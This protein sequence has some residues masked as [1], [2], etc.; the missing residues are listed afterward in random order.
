M[1]R[2]SSISDDGEVAEFDS[3]V[4][5]G[6]EIKRLRPG[7]R[8]Q[9][10]LRLLFVTWFNSGQ[11]LCDGSIN[12]WFELLISQYEPLSFSFSKIVQLIC[13]LKIWPRRAPRSQG[14]TADGHGELRDAF[15]C[16]VC[17][18]HNTNSEQGSLLMPA[19]LV[20]GAMRSPEQHVAAV[21]K[22]LSEWGVDWPNVK[23]IVAPLADGT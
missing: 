16:T 1:D 11:F 4:L 20:G 14:Y 13:P 2:L 7:V 21:V 6:S 23:L 3:V 10:G 5:R 9:H 12:A 8:V 17:W 22:D 18:S 15:F 19:K